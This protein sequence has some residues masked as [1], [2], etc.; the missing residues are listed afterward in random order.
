MGA[1]AQARTIVTAPA[2]VRPVSV[3][4]FLRTGPHFLTPGGGLSR[5]LSSHLGPLG[6]S[7]HRSVA[8]PTVRGGSRPGDSALPN[9]AVPKARSRPALYLRSRSQRRVS[10]PRRVRSAPLA[11]GSPSGGLR[12]LTALPSLCQS[13]PRCTQLPARPQASVPSS[14]PAGRP[15]SRATGPALPEVLGLS[16]P[17]CSWTV[18]S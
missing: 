9:A 18:H 8:A 15:A 4:G 2:S 16:G 12:V 3:R 11:L 13:P 10:G 5:H 6:R 17:L 14:L 1:V 7:V